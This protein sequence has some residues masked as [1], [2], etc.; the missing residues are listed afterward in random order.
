MQQTPLLKVGFIDL[1]L[2]LGCLGIIEMVIVIVF[3][4]EI[5]HNN[6]LKFL[7]SDQPLE[8]LSILALIAGLLALFNYGFDLFTESGRQF[9]LR[10]YLAIAFLFELL[11]LGCLYLIY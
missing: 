3:W 6:S 8:T 2:L 7:R 1:F 10:R 5:A 4:D 11:L 9:I